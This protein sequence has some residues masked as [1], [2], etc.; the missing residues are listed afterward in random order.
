M[1]EEESLVSE[2][3]LKQDGEITLF[4]GKPFTGIC[5]GYYEKN[6][7]KYKAHYKDGK[8]D[9]TWTQWD[10]MGKKELEENYKDGKDDGLE[11]TLENWR[12]YKLHQ[13]A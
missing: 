13:L 5:V 8:L 9:G 7:I 2:Y 1:N 6:I 12:T 3:D 4:E 10:S 11:K